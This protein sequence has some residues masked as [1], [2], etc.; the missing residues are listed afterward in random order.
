MAVGV[1]SCIVSVSCSSLDRRMGHI[2]AI[3]ADSGNQLHSLQFLH[4]LLPN[5]IFLV[6]MGFHHVGQAGLELLT[7]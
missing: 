2:M 7:L 5:L 3:N 1:T 4:L 6:E